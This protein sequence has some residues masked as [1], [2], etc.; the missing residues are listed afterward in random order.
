MEFSC[1]HD[2]EQSALLQGIVLRVT[3][4]LQKYRLFVYTSA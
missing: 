4:E 3:S 1:E 2:N